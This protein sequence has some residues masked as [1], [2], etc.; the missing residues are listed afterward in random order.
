[1]PVGRLILLGLLGLV[2]AE[3]AVFLMVAQLLGSFTALFL[4]FATS[5]LGALVLGRMG[6]RLA[7]RLA[8]MLSQRDLAVHRSLRRP[9]DHDRRPAAGAAGLPHRHRRVAAADP[10]DPAPADRR[11]RNCGAT[12][13]PARCSNSIAASG[14][15]CPNS[16]IEDRDAKIGQTNSALGPAPGKA[17][18]AAGDPCSVRRRVLATPPQRRRRMTQ[19]DGADRISAWR[20]RPMAARRLADPQQAPQLNVLAQYIKD[21][22]FENPN[23]PRSLQPSQTQPAD[24]YPDQRQ[25]DADRSPITR[26]I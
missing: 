2:V 4:L 18:H 26:S 22:S 8:D 25:R 23:A 6:K 7:G 24:Q 19:Q 15:T 16:H 9:S 3:A 21:F 14:A 13:R 11:A 17:P 20:T 1:M 12:A 10:G 5:I